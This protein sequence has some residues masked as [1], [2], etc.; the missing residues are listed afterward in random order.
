MSQ[1][2]TFLKTFIGVAMQ[3]DPV[4]RGVPKGASCGGNGSAMHWDAQSTANR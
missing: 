2:G 3:P 4:E 1:K